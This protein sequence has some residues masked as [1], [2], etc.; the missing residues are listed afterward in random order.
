MS[1]NQLILSGETF[2]DDLLKCGVKD[3]FY[4]HYWFVYQP[5]YIRRQ[6]VTPMGDFGKM[7]VCALG[8][9]RDGT[10]LDVDENET[11]LEPYLVKNRF[12]KSEAALEIVLDEC[13]EDP[14]IKNFM[15]KK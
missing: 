11:R 12:D 5:E 6:H 2:R 4:L 14:R 9:C 7:V 3:K 15:P 8:F 1:I 10:P 13:L